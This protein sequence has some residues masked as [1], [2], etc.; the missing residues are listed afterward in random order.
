MRGRVLVV[1]PR[2]SPRRNTRVRPLG[3]GGSGGGEGVSTGGRM[4]VSLSVSRGSVTVSCDML[5]KL[6]GGQVYTHREKKTE[7]FL[8]PHRTEEWEVLPANVVLRDR[9]STFSV[10]H[11]GRHVSSISLTSPPRPLSNGFTGVH[12]CRHSPCRSAPTC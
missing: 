10:C 4:A 5:P 7:S 8:C 11:Q 2:P 6:G 12:T 3:L 9:F 1:S